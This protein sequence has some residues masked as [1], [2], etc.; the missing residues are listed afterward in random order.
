M[1][2]HRIIVQQIGTH[3]HTEKFY[4]STQVITPIMINITTPSRKRE[5]GT[6][7][8][9]LRMLSTS[10]NSRNYTPSLHHFTTS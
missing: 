6:V 10:S 3:V 2:D 4:R 5:Q 8:Y 9:T 1:T 7:N